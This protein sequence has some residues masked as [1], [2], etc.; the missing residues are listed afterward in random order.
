MASLRSTFALFLT[1]KPGRIFWN[2][3]KEVILRLTYF[4]K[5]K[6]SNFGLLL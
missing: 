4:F 2:G 5:E 1:R 3:T 6:Q